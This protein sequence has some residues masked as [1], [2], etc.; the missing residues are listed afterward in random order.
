MLQYFQ[1]IIRPKNS[2]TEQ[3]KLEKESQKM[4]LLQ[5]QS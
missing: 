4:E 3:V 1:K 5:Y 2:S